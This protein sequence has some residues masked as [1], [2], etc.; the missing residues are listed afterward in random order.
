MSE[1]MKRAQE[2][3]ISHKS[4]ISYL[5]NLHLISDIRPLV[6]V[7]RYQLQRWIRP[8]NHWYNCSIRHDLDLNPGLES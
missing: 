1:V 8:W 3:H 2:R 7:L 4:R 6:E 5:Q